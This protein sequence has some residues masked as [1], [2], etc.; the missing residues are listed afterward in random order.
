MGDI[1]HLRRPIDLDRIREIAFTPGFAWF[2]NAEVMA[3][4]RAMDA[5]DEEIAMLKRR[6]EDWL[7][8]G[9]PG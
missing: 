3:V 6:M 9:R 2:D 5:K 7:D 1:P 4:F 8:A